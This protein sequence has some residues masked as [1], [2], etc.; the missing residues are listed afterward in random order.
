M[1]LEPIRGESVAGIDE[2]QIGPPHS[3]AMLLWLLLFGKGVRLR[4][5]QS[6]PDVIAAIPVYVY[7]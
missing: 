4:K 1:A 3:T 5:G 6:R 7:Q 2:P